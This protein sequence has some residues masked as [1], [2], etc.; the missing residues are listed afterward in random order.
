MPIALQLFSL[1]KKVCN[2]VKRPIGGKQA[3]HPYVYQPIALIFLS[4]FSVAALGAEKVTSVS[5]ETA[6]TES[7]TAPPI[8]NIQEQKQQDS[9]LIKPTIL[10]FY[11]GNR[12]SLLN[13]LVDSLKPQ[14]AAKFE[15]HEFEFIDLFKYPNK[16]IESKLKN[17]QNC[18]MTLGVPATQ[19]ILAY[20]RPLNHFSLLL[21]R[22]LLDK[23]H[24]VYGRLGI[25]VSGIYHEQPIERQIYLAKSLN[26]D[27]QRVNIFL[28]QSDKYYLPEYQKSVNQHG[29]ML[30]SKIL[31]STDSPEKHLTQLKNFDYL[32]ITNNLY[33]YSKSKLASLVLSS[34]YREIRLIGNLYEH[35]ELGTLASIY[36]S[37]TSLSIE[38]S[39]QFKND[40]FQEKM[41]SPRYAQG[42]SVAV[43]KQIATNLNLTQLNENELSRRVSNMEHG[44]FKHD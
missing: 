34:F 2:L 17:T 21:P 44:K 26:A 43:N 6:N 25:Q 7:V 9:S 1:Y 32:L 40:C 18:V 37:P 31:P 23:F 28:E 29:L 8:E 30:N 14:L 20:R 15:K 42:F 39:N 11:E 12:D 19:K 16:E 10:V 5:E 35:A 41:N 36:T 27:I 13:T 38:A 22:P 24:H 3:N 4:I 33:L